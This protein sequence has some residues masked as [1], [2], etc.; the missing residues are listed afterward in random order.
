[1]ERLEYILAG[2]EPKKKAELVKLVAPELSRPWLPTAGPQ[3]QAFLSPADLLLYGGAAGGGKS[4]LGCGLA[5]TEHFRTVVFRSQ[6]TD[7]NGF[8]E[9]LTEIYPNPKTQ[10]SNIKKLTTHDGRMIECGH[11][12]APGS[13]RGW[14]GRP[15]D[16][17]FIDEAAQLNP[18]RVNFVL[19]WLRSAEGRR[20]RAVMG[21][22]PP[23]LGEG[24][25]LLEWFAPWLDPMFPNPARNGELRYGVTVGTASE[26]RTIWLD[27]PESIYLNDDKTWR[28]ATAE[29]IAA[30]PP[31]D[32][33]T[34]PL[35]RTFIPARLDDNPYLR[36]TNYRAQL[37]SQPEPL[38]SQLLK[39]DFLAGRIDDEWQVIPSEWVRQAQARWVDP[40]AKRMIALGVDAAQG[41][42]D[43]STLAPLYEGNVFG[44]VKAKPGVE[45]P[46]GPTLADW[47]LKERRD[48]AAIAIDT[49]GGWGGS[50]RDHL[51]THHQI[52]VI[53]I[54]FSA[55]AEG[56]DNETQL[57]YFNQRARLHWEFRKALDPKNEKE[58]VS[59]PPGEDIMAQ[60]TAARWRPRTGKILVESKED[61][62]ARL[63]SSPDKG[64][65]IMEAWAIRHASY[66]TAA[67]QQ[68]QPTDDGGFPNRLRWLG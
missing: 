26:L 22:N 49:T 21:S 48:G 29:E 8:W 58:P 33:V 43:N 59:L 45:T 4:D 24:V 68:A 20:C 57:G 35:S 1:M 27:G 50:A 54:V 51:K 40:S 34:K 12:D 64:D 39:G 17:I 18:Y 53:A 3:L 23:I 31:L 38:R 7:L 41:G 14:M 11:L 60:L 67:K 66:R 36:G 63:G 15:H 55:G 25:Y 16:L 32:A 37:N 47:I 28:L 52:R 44:R 10:N 2:M 61:I 19:G 65:A 5:L 30:S 46:D 56:G 62:R 9:R 42:A 13:E 6:S